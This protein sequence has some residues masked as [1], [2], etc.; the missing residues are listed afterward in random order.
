MFNHEAQTHTSD[1]RINTK[2]QNKTDTAKHTTQ[3]NDFPSNKYRAEVMK[4]YDPME[5]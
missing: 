5:I 1:Q 3:K 2:T 4:R